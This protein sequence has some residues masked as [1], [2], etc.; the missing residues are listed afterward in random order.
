MLLPALRGF[1][2]K[3]YLQNLQLFQRMLKR[4]HDAAAIYSLEF[5][6]IKMIL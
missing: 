3:I 6:P 1:F 4:A 2:M 5:M